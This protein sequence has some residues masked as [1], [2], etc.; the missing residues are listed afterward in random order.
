MPD[1]M[2]VLEEGLWSFFGAPLLL[3]EVEEGIQPSEI[4]FDSIRF[5]VKAEDV[6][7]N[8]RRKC[9][10]ISLASS[11]GEFVEFDEMDPIG[12]R[13]YL[14][15]RVDIKLNKPLKRFTRVAASGG[16]KWVKFPYE[17]LMDICH[18]CGCLGHGYQQCEKYD[19]SVPVAELPYGNWMRASSTR[20]KLFVD[21]KK[22]EEKR[23]C[24]EFREG[25]R[26]SGV[27]TKLNF[28]KQEGMK[29]LNLENESGQQNLKI[30]AL[31]NN[32]PIVRGLETD[33]GTILSKKSGDNLVDSRIS[34]RGRTE[35]EAYNS[36][37]IFDEGLFDTPMQ[38]IGGGTNNDT[39]KGAGIHN[40]L[41]SP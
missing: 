9:M 15:F 12:W 2:K 18:A 20:K 40:A 8:K 4:V 21:Q 16:S 28:D 37:P 41:T 32:S 22:E 17:R 3:K 6:P 13:K 24:Q 10:A 23:I 33:E 30:R 39:I 34:K 35:S 36:D 14:R 38:E 19:D 26:A 27:R 29:N 31:T 5:W 7:L 11:M 25:L 1:K